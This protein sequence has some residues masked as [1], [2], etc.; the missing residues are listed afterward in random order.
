MITAGDYEGQA[1]KGTVQ[2]GES[3][4][5]TLQLGITMELFKQG[6]KESLGQMTTILYFSEGAAYYSYERLRLL[7]W[8]GKGAEDIDKL[9]DIFS[10]RVPVRVTAPEEYDA[11]DGTKKMGQS[12]LEILTGGGTLPFNKPVTPESFKARL[13][14]LSGSSGGGAPPPAT[15]GGGAAPPF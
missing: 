6:E 14:A 7:G 4:K 9:D 11:S 15:G 10:T 3:D 8:Q 5:G 2:F 1:V 12:K 13:Q